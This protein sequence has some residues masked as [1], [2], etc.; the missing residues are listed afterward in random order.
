MKIIL[1][2]LFALGF[3]S[4]SQA[5]YVPRYEIT[6][7]SSVG[8]S[9]GQGGNNSGTIVGSLLGTVGFILGSSGF[10]LAANPSVNIASFTGFSIQT[11]LGLNIIGEYNFDSEHFSNSWYVFLGPGLNYFATSGGSSTNFQ[12]VSGFGKR[13][14]IVEHLS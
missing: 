2:A 1:M 14:Q 7:G 12:F 4:Q 5:E 13:F 9:V 3:A 10:E 8:T 11:N 6:G